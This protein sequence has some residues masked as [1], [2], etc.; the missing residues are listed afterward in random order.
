MRLK[1]REKN[2]K[3]ADL[4]AALDRYAMDISSPTTSNSR[5]NQ[6]RAAM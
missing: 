5:S 3:I 4:E 6:R 1:L 2:T